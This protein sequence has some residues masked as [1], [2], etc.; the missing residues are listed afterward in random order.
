MCKK[1]NVLLLLVFVFFVFSLLLALLPILD[2]D[3]DGHLDSLVTDGFV[4]LPIFGA[5]IGLFSLLLRLSLVCLSIHQTFST[6]IVPPPIL[7]T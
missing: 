6:L 2:F 4:L 5:I 1:N 3:N 7:T